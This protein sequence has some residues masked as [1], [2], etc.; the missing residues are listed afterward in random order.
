M[1]VM[2]ERISHG[3]FDK[4][5][6]I[7]KVSLDTCGNCRG[8]QKVFVHEMKQQNSQGLGLDV[9]FVSEQEIRR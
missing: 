8:T 3:S 4:D 5:L 9:K 1:I 7:E 2:H 6:A